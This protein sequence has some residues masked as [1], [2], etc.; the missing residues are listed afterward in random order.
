MVGGARVRLPGHFFHF[1][2]SKMTQGRRRPKTLQIGLVGF[3]IS[4]QPIL[5]LQ[6]GLVGFKISRQPIL[7]LQIGLIGFKISRQPDL[8]LQIGLIRLIKIQNKTKL[9]TFILAS[10]ISIVV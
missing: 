2:R 10:S 1:L 4:R 3:K 9:G 6:I 7:T 5:T 8:A